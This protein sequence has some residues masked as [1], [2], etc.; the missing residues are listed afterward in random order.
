MNTNNFYKRETN[1]GTPGASEPPPSKMPENI[2]G[3]KIRGFLKK[4]GM[5]TIY[6]G[7]HPETQEP[8]AIKVLSP[9]Y[10]KDEEVIQRFFRESD[11]IALADHPNIVKLYSQGEW[12]RGLYIAMEY[13]EGTSLYQYLQETTLSL[14]EALEISLQIAYAICHLHSHGVIHRDLKLENILVTKE[15]QV[16]V[17]DFG[18]AQLLDEQQPGRRPRRQ[19]I[20]TPIYMSPEQKLN[21]ESVSYPSDIYSLGII[22]YELVL[23]RTNHGK[24]HLRNMPV[25][26]QPILS[27]SLQP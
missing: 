3:Y 17:I 5:S 26:L 18:I 19:I 6:L 13:I 21:P 24:V 16:K 11:I 10:L 12:E 14:K 1:P 27:K 9:K 23:G 8:V 22:T 20:G 4:G 2:H 7:T 15:G 25:K